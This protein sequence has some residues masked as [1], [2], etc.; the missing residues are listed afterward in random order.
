MNYREALI[1]AIKKGYGYKAVFKETVPIKETFQG[2]TVWEGEVEVFEL[3]G[4][5]KAKYCYGWGFDEGRKTEFA[6][7]LGV[8]PI[9]TPLKAVQ[10]YL[11]L[12]TKNP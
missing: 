9:T 1:D 8:P 4:H 12:K 3:D 5:P 11:I 2:K 7:V 10:A 6:T